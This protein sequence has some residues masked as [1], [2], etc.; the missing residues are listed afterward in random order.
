VGQT[1]IYD[2]E[3]D[4]PTVQWLTVTRLL[5]V[6]NVRIRYASPLMSELTGSA[7]A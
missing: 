1:A 2:V 3:H 7:P 5:D 4:K 6:L